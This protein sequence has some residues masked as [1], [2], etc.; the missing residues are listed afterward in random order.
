MSESGTK[1]DSLEE[2]EICY[3]F[4]YKK[5]S[6]YDIFKI[7]VV[8]NRKSLRGFKNV[9]II[10][11]I[12][13]SIYFLSKFFIVF[14]IIILF[15]V[16]ILFGLIGFYNIWKFVYNYEKK[17]EP[18][19]DLIK[20]RTFKYGRFGIALKILF[21]NKS[22]EEK[23]AWSRYGYMIE[24]GVFLFLVPRLKKADLFIVRAD[25]IGQ[26]NHLEFRDYAKSKLKYYYVKS[27]KEFIFK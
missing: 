13:L 14:I 12:L 15:L 7:F 3:P 20:K 16:L 22:H 9:I 26:D 8:D 21:E 27:I 18:I 10:E 2:K 25:E 6:K 23:Y 11:F 1:N 19:R 24:W 4:G 17:Q 5:S